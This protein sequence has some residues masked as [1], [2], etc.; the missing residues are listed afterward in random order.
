MNNMMATVNERSSKLNFMYEQELSEGLLRDDRINDSVM[1]PSR[2][3]KGTWGRVHLRAGFV[4]AAS[5][6]L[7]QRVREMLSSLLL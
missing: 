2:T 4:D 3:P 7:N 6:L 5:A 1:I